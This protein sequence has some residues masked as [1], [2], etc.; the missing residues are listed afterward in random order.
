MMISATAK[1]ANPQLVDAQKGPAVSPAPLPDR[2]EQP[3]SENFD[4]FFQWV[5]RNA[6]S[7]PEAERDAWMD[8]AVKTLVRMQQIWIEGKR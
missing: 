7:W 3:R 5:R 6:D 2:R 1:S 4:E 8:G